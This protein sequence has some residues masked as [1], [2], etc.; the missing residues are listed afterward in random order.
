MEIF[1]RAE[2]SSSFTIRKAIVKK[3]HKEFYS[4]FEDL[5]RETRYWHKDKRSI[6]MLRF[7]H[8]V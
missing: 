5:R 8:V 1:Y 4:R 6:D 7:L 3:K 2:T